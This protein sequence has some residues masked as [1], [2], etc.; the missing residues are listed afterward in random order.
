M[1]ATECTECF[2]T[3]L[4]LW[5]VIIENQGQI[6]K[7][8]LIYDLY[9]SVMVLIEVTGHHCTWMPLNKETSVLGLKG[10]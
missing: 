6:Q 7:Y 9:C 8:S 10:L 2:F 1:V 3:F 5:F 4:N